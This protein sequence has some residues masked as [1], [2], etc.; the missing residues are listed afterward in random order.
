M[1]RKVLA[2]DGWFDLV[3]IVYKDFVEGERRATSDERRFS[4]A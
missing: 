4:G 3:L 2:L 1:D